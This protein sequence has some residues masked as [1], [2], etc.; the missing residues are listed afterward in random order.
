MSAIEEA[1]VRILLV[2]SIY[3]LIVLV[4]PLFFFPNFLIFHTKIVITDKIRRIAKK[5]KSKNKE[6]T[7]R[8]VYD[9]VRKMYSVRFIERYKLF[10]LPY[11]HFYHNVDKFL[12]KEQFLP[13]SV[14]ALILR[15]LLLATGHFSEKDL[16]KRIIIR[17]SG[18]I[19][20][21][22]LVRMNK[23]TFKVDPFL[24]IYKEMI[25]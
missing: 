25:N 22:Y 20:S 14:Q 9:Y 7:L 4:I 24:R 16:R 2:L 8:N 11:K 6:R 5:L 10:A 3:L 15:T 21:Y 17:P 1:F 19:H 23:K 18:M 12:G 13:C